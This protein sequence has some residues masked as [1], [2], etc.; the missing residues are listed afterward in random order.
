MKLVRQVVFSRRNILGIVLGVV[1]SVIFI[2][3][4]KNYVLASILGMMITLLIVDLKQPGELAMLGFVTGSMAGL[5]SEAR[6][7]VISM[8]APVNLTDTGLITSMLGG[9][10]WTGLVCGGYAFVLGIIFRLL[11]RGERPFF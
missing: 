7:Y 8:E 4:M 9:L 6:N 2:S 11:A 5:Y 3:L 1:A 10:I